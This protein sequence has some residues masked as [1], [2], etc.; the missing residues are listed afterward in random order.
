MGY[1]G[2]L[3]EAFKLGV[4]VQEEP[5][6]GKLKGLYSDNVIWIDKNLDSNKERHCIMAEELGHYHTSSGDI[7]NQTVLNS[8][9]QEVR[10]RSWAYERAVPLEMI[11]EAHKEFIR[12]RFELA[13]FLDVT[14][15]F[16]N[17]AILRYKEKYGNTVNLK[18]Y[19]ICFE[20]LGVIEWF[21]K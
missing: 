3:D 13:N 10:A 2:L 14:E 18:G 12:N 5:I 7:L 17:Q 9:K 15:E 21:D 19:T 4:F 8:R 6:K 16:L 20:P 11:I 1:E